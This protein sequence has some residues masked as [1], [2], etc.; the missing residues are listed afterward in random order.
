MCAHRSV[1]L[2]FSCDQYGLL[3]HLLFWSEMLRK[4]RVVRLG[5]NLYL[6][7]YIHLKSLGRKPGP[8]LY[9]KSFINVREDYVARG[10]FLYK[11]MPILCFCS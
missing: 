6:H 9:R 7:E 3:R 2:G 5:F 1:Y 4:C 10:K 11:H 8:T